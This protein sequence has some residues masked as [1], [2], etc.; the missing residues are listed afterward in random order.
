ML[1]YLHAQT[2]IDCCSWY[3]LSTKLSKSRR[4][5]SLQLEH[6]EVGFDDLISDFRDKLDVPYFFLTLDIFVDINILKG[7]KS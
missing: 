5:S 4:P 2:V 6:S 1:Q 3:E 7:L